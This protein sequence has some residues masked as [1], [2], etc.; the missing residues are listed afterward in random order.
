MQHFAPPMTRRRALLSGA[1][2]VLV[3]AAAAAEERAG[4]IESLRGDAFAEGPKPRRALQS[5]APVF[6][7]DLIETLVNSALTMHL[8]KATVVKLGALTKFRIDNFVVDAGG[9]FDLDQGPMLID[10]NGRKDEDLRV[11]SPYGL[12]AVRGTMF[13]A[14]PSN[15]VFGVFVARG[16]VAVTGGGRTVVLRPGLGTNIAHPG[17]APTEPRRWSPGRIKAALRSVE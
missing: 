12:M 2:V 16:V 14:G 6:I 8:G 7:G 1:A 10:H 17:D 5:M 13:F 3:G 15:D 4:T 9:T 11:R